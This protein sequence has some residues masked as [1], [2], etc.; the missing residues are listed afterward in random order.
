MEA[1]GDEVPSSGSH[2]GGAEQEGKVT[3]SI[4]AALTWGAPGTRPKRVTVTSC[5]FVQCPFP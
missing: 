3:G 4:S 5:L 2:L 1:Q